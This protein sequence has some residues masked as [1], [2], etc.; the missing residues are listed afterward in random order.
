MVIRVK[1]IN[2][3]CGA[4][5]RSTGK[6]CKMMAVKPGGKCRLHGGASTGPRTIKGRKQSSI[7]I[8]AYNAQK[9]A[10]E[11]FIGSE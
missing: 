7:T 8:S 3:T 5:S 6:P 2:G 4:Y 9:R 10:K 11:R 1:K